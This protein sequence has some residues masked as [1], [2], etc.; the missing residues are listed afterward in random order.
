MVLPRGSQRPV[1]ELSRREEKTIPARPA[2]PD[3]DKVGRQ[4]VASKPPLSRL[5]CEWKNPISPP[6]S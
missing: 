4:T 3:S 6:P 5:C 2:D 1:N